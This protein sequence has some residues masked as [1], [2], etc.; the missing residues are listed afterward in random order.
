MNQVDVSFQ[1]NQGVVIQGYHV[2]VGALAPKIVSAPGRYSHID[3][4]DP[5]VDTISTISAPYEGPEMWIIV[6]LNA[7]YSE[8]Y[9]PSTPDTPSLPW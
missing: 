7:C 4:F 6:H 8:L 3:Y 1:I 2:H 5:P 9:N